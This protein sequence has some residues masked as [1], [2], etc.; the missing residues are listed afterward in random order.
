MRLGRSDDAGAEMI[1]LLLVAAQL[2]VQAEIF[3][4]HVSD[5][6]R[7]SVRSRSERRYFANGVLRLE[8]GDGILLFDTAKARV[9]V[10][11][12]ATRTYAKL[13]LAEYDALWDWSAAPPADL[14][15]VKVT[16]GD[17]DNRCELNGLFWDMALRIHKTT[18]PTSRDAAHMQIALNRLRLSAGSNVFFDFVNHRRGAVPEAAACFD[19]EEL[20]VKLETDARNDFDR[21]TGSMT[22]SKILE[23]P[24]LPEEL[25][26]IPADWTEARG[27]AKSLFNVLI[28]TR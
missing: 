27:D 26:Q 8:S 22:V 18:R 2:E 28:K 24:S 1:A 7:G 20:I 4:R 14:K 3:Y 13:S 16:T 5:D 9:T 25:F 11:S 23:H 6:F 15:V 17:H 19:G 12:K 21:A 10:A